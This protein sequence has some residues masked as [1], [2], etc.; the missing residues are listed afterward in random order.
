MAEDS[1]LSITGN[2]LGILTFAVAILLGAYTRA[3]A[4]S[5]EVERIMLLKIEVW[6]AV[7]VLSQNYAD[8][9]MIARAATQNHGDK[10][11]LKPLLEAGYTGV[12]KTMFALTDMIARSTVQQALEGDE[13][14][15]NLRKWLKEVESSKLRLLNRQS[16][17][18]QRYVP[19]ALTTRDPLLRGDS[20]QKA[21]FRN[22]FRL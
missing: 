21:S 14:I 12:S 3:I 19:V 18:W 13:K 22:L 2:V 7:Q 20:Q 4:I 1:P 10:T 6:E 15:T 8:F 17:M 9:D 11:P 5:Q 16:I